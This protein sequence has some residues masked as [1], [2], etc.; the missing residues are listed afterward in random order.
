ML[1]FKKN[2][3]VSSNIN[4]EF[5]ISIP[6]FAMDPTV[7]VANTKASLIKNLLLFNRNFHKFHR[8]LFLC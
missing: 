3:V 4:A 8:I 1:V 2:V 5:K 6:F 7:L